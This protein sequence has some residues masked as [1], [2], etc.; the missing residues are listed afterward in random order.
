M[1][2]NR[3]LRLVVTNGCVLIGLAVIFYFPALFIWDG[4]E[5]QYWEQRMITKSA[6][7]IASLSLF[8]MWLFACGFLLLLLCPLFLFAGFVRSARH[9]LQNAPPKFKSL[10]RIATQF[11]KAAMIGIAVFIAFFGI[12]LA[13]TWHHPPSSEPSVSITPISYTNC[14]LNSTGPSAIVYPEH[15]TRLQV[16]LKNEGSES[17]SLGPIWREPYGWA[18]VE[19]DLGSTN[20]YLA[21]PYN[22]ETSILH[23]GSAITFSATLPTNT[24]RWQCVFTAETASWRDRAICRIISSR[25]YGRIP[26]IFFQPVLYLPNISGPALEVKSPMLKVKIKLKRPAEFN[27]YAYE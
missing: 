21:P 8:K 18:V 13:Y 7:T 20:L 4:F 17:V 2:K 6:D 22:G 27:Q 24:V 14:T 11:F 12:W 3:I 1:E 10:I 15:G 16:K 5:N 25:F 9:G 23:P 19:T 26:D